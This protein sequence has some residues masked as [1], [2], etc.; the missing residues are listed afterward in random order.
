MRFELQHCMTYQACLHKTQGWT[1]VD[2]LSSVGM[3]AGAIG[4]CGVCVWGGGQGGFV[5]ECVLGQGQ[6]KAQLL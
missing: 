6:P 2:V 5:D 1:N 4:G 3:D